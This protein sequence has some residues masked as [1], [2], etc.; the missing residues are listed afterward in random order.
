MNPQV[1]PASTWEPGLFF[2]FFPL[3]KLWITESPNIFKQILA[4]LFVIT[5]K[6]QMCQVSLKYMEPNSRVKDL[7][8][9]SFF[10]FF[11]NVAF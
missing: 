3:F 7:K 5:G 9:A 2:M 4:D 1:F 6:D 11:Q 8:I 10:S